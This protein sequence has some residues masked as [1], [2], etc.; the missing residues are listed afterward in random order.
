[1]PYNKPSMKYGAQMMSKRS[2]IN[3]VGALA[4]FVMPL[5][6]GAII[7]AVGKKLSEKMPMK[8]GASLPMKSKPTIC[9]HNRSK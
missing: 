5:I 1:M 7:N 4:A 2:G 8:S 6:K 9:K 3:A